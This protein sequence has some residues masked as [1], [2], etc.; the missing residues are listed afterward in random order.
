M[1]TKLRKPIKREIE[2]EGETYTVTLSPEGLRLTRKGFR[3]GH[4]VSWKSLQAT[5]QKEGAE[6]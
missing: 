1:P 6:D 4:A 3:K 2:I 5:A